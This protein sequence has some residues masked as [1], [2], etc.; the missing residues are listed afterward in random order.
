MLFQCN[1][2]NVKEYVPTSAVQFDFIDDPGDDSKDLRARR[3]RVKRNQSVSDHTWKQLVENNAIVWRGHYECARACQRV[4]DQSEIQEP[5]L[6]HIDINDLVNSSSP[7]K[8]RTGQKRKHSNA[9]KH[10]CEV[11]LHV[12]NCWALTTRLFF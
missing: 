12:S 6:E 7:P 3:C 1:D 8:K 5:T 2:F 9:N 10:R 11:V 4:V